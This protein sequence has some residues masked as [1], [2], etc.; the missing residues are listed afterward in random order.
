MRRRL[1]EGGRHKEKPVRGN[2]PASDLKRVLGADA[3][4][5]R[6]N[7]ETGAGARAGGDELAR[8]AQLEISTELPTRGGLFGALER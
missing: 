3:E 2:V 8:Q 4:G 5:R 6:R 7:H 1:V